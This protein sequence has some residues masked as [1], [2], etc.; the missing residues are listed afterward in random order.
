MKV[1][2]LPAIVCRPPIFARLEHINH[3]HRLV[4]GRSLTDPEHRR[5]LQSDQGTEEPLP[6]VGVKSRRGTVHIDGVRTAMPACRDRKTESKD[7]SCEARVRFFELPARVPGHICI[8]G[9]RQS[10]L[11][12]EHRTW[13]SEMHRPRPE[14]RSHILQIK[15]QVSQLIR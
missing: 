8:D 1:T 6:Q 15:Q 7:N 14:S 9:T 4:H 3:N 5:L 12:A 13:G 2:G 10:I 11:A